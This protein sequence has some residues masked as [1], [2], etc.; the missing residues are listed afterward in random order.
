MTTRNHR[1]GSF[2][3]RRMKIYLNS[4]GIQIKENGVPGF[5]NRDLKRMCAEKLGIVLVLGRDNSDLQVY[6][7]LADAGVSTMPRP[8]KMRKS[9]AFLES[10]EWMEIRYRA[11]KLHGGRCQCCGTAGEPSNPLQVDHI[12]PRSK[13][14]ELAL[15]LDNLQ[16]LCRL[17]NLGKRAW[18]ETD[19]RDNVV[20]I[21]RSRGDRSDG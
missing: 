18:D 14:P 13:F 5:K 21:G 16:V 2:L 8:S 4:L 10:A 17:C 3:R 20:P 7:A 6:E 9:Q 1:L 15:V 19:W 12:K 11:L